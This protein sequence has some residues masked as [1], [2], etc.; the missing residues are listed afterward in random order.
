[1]KRQFCCQRTQTTDT[2]VRV[3]RR[4]EVDWGN[5]LNR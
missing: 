1:V 3:R 2:D 4:S 5:T